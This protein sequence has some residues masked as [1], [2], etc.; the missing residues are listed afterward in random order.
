V[1][2]GRFRFIALGKAQAEND[3]E[4]EVKIVADA[5]TDKILGV[6][7]VGAHATDLIH[8][9]ALAV[10]HGLTVEQLGDAF[11]AHPVMAEAVLEAA[12]DVHGLSIHTLKSGK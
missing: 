2:I 8:E 10:R 12:H 5:E 9:S 6:H 3:I 4:G 11:Q 1:K 7:I